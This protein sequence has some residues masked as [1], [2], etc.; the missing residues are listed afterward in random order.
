MKEKFHGMDTQRQGF[1]NRYDLRTLLE[2]CGE[3][4][5]DEKMNSIVRMIEEN[6]FR[7]IDINTSLKCWAFLKELNAKEEEEGFDY[8]ILNA[9][10]AMGGNTDKSGFVK[11][12]TIVNIVKNVFGLTIDIEQMF[13]EAGIEIEDELNFY[14]FT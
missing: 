6:G 4:P 10:V 2:Q 14:E 11:K 5:S 12:S 3:S 9:F 13:E 7:R 8:D 1:I